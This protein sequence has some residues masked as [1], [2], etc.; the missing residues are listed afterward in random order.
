MLGTAQQ[1]TTVHSVLPINND[2]LFLAARRPYQEPILRHDV[3]DMDVK[4]PWCGALHWMNEKLSHSSRTNPIFGLCCDSGKVVLP[5]L[6]DP[7][8][9]L[10]ALLEGND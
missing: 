9:P 4:C 5:V 7:P 3:G 6:Q 8:R 1:L 2:S 10:K